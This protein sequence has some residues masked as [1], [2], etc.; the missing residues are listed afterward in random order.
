MPDNTELIAQL[1]ELQES[2]LDRQNS[3][4]QEINELRKEINKI[5]FSPDRESLEDRKEKLDKLLLGLD[6]LLKK[7][8]DLSKEVNELRFEI[9]KL[10]NSQAHEQIEEKQ[11]AVIEQTKAPSVAA[12]RIAPIYQIQQPKI[13]SQSPNRTIPKINVPDKSDLEKFIGENLIN[14]IGIAIIIIGV[15]IGA[16][17]SIEH[18]WIS[19]LTRIVLGYLVGLGLLGFGIKLKKEYDNFSAVLV[20]GAIAIMY[21]IT[22]AAY[23]FYDLI[24]QTFAFG[25][26]VVF[27]VFTVVAAISYNKQ[28]I[29]HIGLVGAYAVP[30]ILSDGSGKVAILFSYMSIINV[31]ILVIAF[32]RYWK[33]LYYSS[34]AITWIIFLVWFST[35]YTVANYYAVSLIFISIFFVTFYIIFLAYKLIRKEMFEMEDIIL[36]LINSFIF[37]ALGY[38]IL[39]SHPV[40][41]QLLGLFALCNAIIHFGVCVLIY[42][43]K[44]ADRNLFFL[45]AGLVLVFITITIP[46]QLDGNWVTLLWVGEAA[47]LFWIGRY[48]NVYFYEKASYVLMVLSFISLMLD[49]SVVY[50]VY[51]N[52]LITPI[53]NINFLSS[54]LFICAFVFINHI[55]V[56]TDRHTDASVG[57]SLNS[58]VSFVIPGILLFVLYFSFWMEISSYWDQLYMSSKVELKNIA[59][60]YND[61]YYNLDL[62][63]F[64]TVWLI[65]YSLLFFSLL[66][67]VN[68]IKLKNRNL[69]LVNLGLNVFSILVFLTQGLYILSSLRDGYLLKILSEYYQHS[70]FNI[71]VRY[72]SYSFVVLSF[73]SIYRYLQQEFLNPLNENIKVAF[74]GLLYT[75]IIW[76][77]SAELITWLSILQYPETFKLGLS[78]LW[79]VYALVLIVLGIW[80]KKKHLRIGGIG[81]FA[82]TLAKL[83]LYDIAGLN[84][85]SKTIVFLSLGLLLLIISFLYNKYKSIINNDDEV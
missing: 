58:F 54:V 35:S 59:Q 71:G 85:I 37:F 11:Y 52:V 55:R 16:K 17:Y 56:K 82:V 75:T 49:W 68:I 8:T 24:P 46:I 48:K 1:F 31:G 27:T 40:G 50:N 61:T 18:G 21:F 53:L 39:K 29:A 2:L 72:V 60:G 28:V 10:T 65:N 69:G 76:V 33:P 19:P 3:F 79:G 45:L 63:H 14:K 77:L 25:L 26:M 5:K 70:S 73:V 38:F 67:F 66:S 34:Y 44:L 9:N 74:D 13:E 15:A 7:Q 47:L 62:S 30:F 78:I 32:K 57:N 64:K 41:V 42:K 22:Y 6:I 12:T 81:L 36:L 51:D 4:A 80:K 83:F 84:T 20:S 43:Q 23:G